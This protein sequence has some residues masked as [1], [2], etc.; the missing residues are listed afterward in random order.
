M[1]LVNWSNNETIRCNNNAFVFNRM[2]GYNTV[3]YD[4]KTKNWYWDEEYSQV[5]TQFYDVQ[6]CNSVQIVNSTYVVQKAKLLNYFA[7]ELK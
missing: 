4:I 7:T 1:N 3:F 6:K 5:T 2:I